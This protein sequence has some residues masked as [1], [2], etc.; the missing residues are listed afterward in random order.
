MNPA[1]ILVPADPCNW[2][3]W[4]LNLWYAG[5]EAHKH[6]FQRMVCGCRSLVR[7]SAALDTFRSDSIRT[8]LAGDRSEPVLDSLYHLCTRICVSGLHL[9]IANSAGSRRIQDDEKVTALTGSYDGRGRSASAT[10]TLATVAYDSNGNTLFDASGRSFTWDFENRLIQVVNPGVGTTT[11]R[12]DPFGRRI[13]KSGPLG[14]TNYLYDGN[15]DI[16]EVDNAGNMLA[17]YIQGNH[18]DEPYAEQRSGTTSYYE[19]DGGD[20]ATSL[21]SSAGA[22]ANSYA[23]DSF[24]KLMCRKVTSLFLTKYAIAGIFERYDEATDLRCRFTPRVVGVSESRAA[25][26]WLCSLSGADGRQAHRSQAAEGRRGRSAEVVAD[27]RG[28]TFRTVYTVKLEKAVYVLNAFQKKS[29][30]GI[31]TPKS[32]MDLVKQRLQRAI[33]IEREREK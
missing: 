14:T 18:I 19:G 8:S 7:C 20:S 23:Y 2:L 1:Q 25:A 27:H 15:N 6:V 9:R 28:D 33:E 12:Y 26:G 17:R 11:F 10:T 31:A 16:G 3:Q 22:V 5:F 4:Y 24:G 30:H 13:Q 21:T 29:K 32:V